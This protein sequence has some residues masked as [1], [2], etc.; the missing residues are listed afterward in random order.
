MSLR[1]FL[2]IIRA[3]FWFAFLILLT[4]LAVTVGWLM[5]RTPTYTAR[6]P[7]VVDARTADPVPGS[8]G[9]G[10]I[11]ESFIATQIDIIK[12]ERV[13]ERVVQM[14]EL[15][16]DPTAPER[17]QKEGKG[18]GTLLSWLA[19][20]LQSGLEVRPARES[21]IINIT[22]TARTPEGAA[23][24]ANGFAQ[25]YLD[26]SVELRTDPA[27]RYSV[28][29]ED[30]LR[31]SKQNMQRAQT[32]LSEFQQRAGIV[33]SDERVDH[34]T[35]R[36]NELSTQ[37]S[38]IQA[39]TTDSQNKRSASRDTVSEVIQSTLINGLKADIGRLDAKVQESAARLG[40]NH[41]T[42]VSMNAE[43][44][45]LRARLTAETSKISASI[46]TTYQVGKGRELE[47]QSAVAAQRA[48]VLG[49][50]KQR[51][52]LSLLQRDVDSAQKA[53]EAVSAGASQ[54]KLQSLTNQ[55]NVMRLAEAVRPLQPAGLTDSQVL[56]VGTVAGLLMAIVGAFLLE[57]LNRRV[58]TA[59][60]LFMALD[61]PVLA[62]IPVAGASSSALLRLG[63]P[64]RLAI[65]DARS[66]A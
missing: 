12:S 24:M 19:G 4:T 34:E 47:L 57:L 22:Y 53:F 3:R 52:E 13:A 29:F 54:S 30:Q 39:Q 25:A 27:R 50:N 11:S 2:A 7:L 63:G 8:Q 9:G 5:L 31:E 62:S 33:S 49:L 42:M 21:N 26:T 36:L 35:S 18:A 48:R 58:R 51:G 32:R 45:S 16:K 23:R 38:A 55:T 17:W 1:Q 6:A 66:P 46:D 61:L 37:L 56:T 64:R 15:D 44:S 65:G 60:D 20:D 43:L 59:D 40:P 14:L 28:W 41:P 10:N